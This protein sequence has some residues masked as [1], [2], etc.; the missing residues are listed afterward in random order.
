M[1]GSHLLKTWSSTQASVALSSGEAEFYGAVKAAGYGLAYQ[2]L[3]AD[4][5][6]QMPVTCFSD[7]A[8]AIGIASRQGLG[9]LRHLDVHTLWL[10]QAVRSKR[11]ALRKVL[12]T[13]NPADVFTKHLAS[14]E[15]MLDLARL[16][17]LEYRAGRPDASPELRREDRPRAEM[18]DMES[19]GDAVC[20]LPHM[21]PDRDQK[22]PIIEPAEDW[23]SFD[24]SCMQGFDYLK[25]HA[26]KV[27]EDV[28]R[29]VDVYGRRRRA[30]E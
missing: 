22:Y 4:L 19:S 5:G 14:R 1:V 26:D 7:S 3:L 15:K 20:L 16:Y 25:A 13:D 11:I 2:A 12:G 18:K 8:A 10:Q 6:I 21:Q 28:E 30:P 29:E 23:E 17:D 9:K 27:I 24:E